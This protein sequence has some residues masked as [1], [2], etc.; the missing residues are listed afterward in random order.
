MQII[1]SWPTQY[2]LASQI[3]VANYRLRNA[4]LTELPKTFRPVPICARYHVSDNVKN[5][6]ALSAAAQCAPTLTVTSK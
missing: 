3:L 6:R 2:S 1:V 5:T 4:A